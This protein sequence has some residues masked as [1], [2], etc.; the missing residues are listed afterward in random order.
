MESEAGTTT[1]KT[2]RWP[3]VLVGFLLGA[4]VVSGCLGI[5]FPIQALFYLAGGWF[6]FL[7]RVLPS[8]SVSLS[9]IITAFAFL[10][11]MAVIIQLLG[12]FLIRNIRMKTE[13]T[14]LSGW[15][16][17]WTGFCLLLLVVAFTGGFAVVGVAHQS[18]WIVT[19]S[20][21]IIGLA[22]GHRGPGRKERSQRKL[23]NIAY[24][25]I[26]F[27]SG[28]EG[29][30][31][32]GGSISSTGLPLHS[33]ETELLPYLGRLKY[34]QQI[35]RFQ[36]WNS[37]TNAKLFQKPI[38]EF[39]MPGSEWPEQNNQGFGLSYYTLNSHISGLKERASLN[40]IP[41]GVSNTLLG[42]E[43]VSQLRAW[44]DPVNFRDPALGINSHQ[45]GFGGPW[46]Q[47]RGA[48][49][50]FLDGSARFINENID[51]EILKALATPHGGEDV[52]TFLEG[53]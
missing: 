39:L 20:E 18:A 6:L 10:V 2:K 21:G 36:P 13:M 47:R 33:W 41:D 42:G 24:E 23:K 45:E 26:N 4:V 30:R 31:F 38:R 37:K 51:P 11:L 43:V 5:L 35:D 1:R 9:G 8:V 16:I 32:P 19:A 15:R 53:R 46:Q 3:K 49:M 28:A 52:S 29:N 7:K 14:P 27:A 40:R 44:G 25:T 48:N 17:R 34:Y 50:V 22:S 12:T